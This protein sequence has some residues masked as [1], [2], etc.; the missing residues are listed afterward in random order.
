MANAMEPRL[1]P[2]T[3]TPDRAAQVA[4]GTAA[5]RAMAGSEVPRAVFVLGSGLGSWAGTLDDP[6]SCALSAIPGVPAPTVAGHAGRFVMGRKAGVWVAA[7]SGRVHA[8]EGHA[9]GTLTLALEAVLGLG[10]PIV[11]LTNAAGAVNMSFMPGEL[12]VIDDQVNFTNVP[13]LRSLW[14]AAEPRMRDAGPV[15]SRRLIALAETAALA[16]GLQLRRGLYFASRGPTYE[17]P[18]E[19]RMAARWGADAVGMSTVAES[20]VAAARGAEVLGISCLTNRA[21]G[22]SPTPLTHAEV[23]ETAALA[24]DA[25]VALLDDIAARMGA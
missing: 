24:H 8:Y 23:M 3:P 10:T 18:A 15:Y 19:V 9:V 22:L 17:T 20:A 21:A 16:R 1:S 7:L 14:D 12:M 13:P 25:F 11:V 4:A 6:R 5:L 2:A